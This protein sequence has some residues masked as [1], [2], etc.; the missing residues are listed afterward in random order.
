MI[1]GAECWPAKKKH[2]NKI[3]VAEMRML[4][5]LRWFR[6]LNHRPIEAPVRKIE[7]LDFAHVQ[8]GR[9]RPKKT[10]QETIRSDLSYLN[11]DKNL[12]TDRAQGK[13]RIHVADP[14]QWD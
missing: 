7:L 9:G 14:T 5:G 10:W 4:S 12:V 11:L 13:Q 2:T 8:R 1:Y 6:Y 3:N